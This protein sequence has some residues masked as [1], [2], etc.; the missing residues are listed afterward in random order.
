MLPDAMR[1]PARMRWVHIRPAAVAAAA[2]TAT[3]CTAL[4]IST[5]LLGALLSSSRLGSSAAAA[6]AAPDSAAS[7]NGVQVH[8]PGSRHRVPERAEEV[9]RQLQASQRDRVLAVYRRGRHVSH[10]WRAGGQRAVRAP[11]AG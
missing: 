9:L 1:V 4:L 5:A 7:G 6:R 3:I 8:A 10:R 2:T 11:G